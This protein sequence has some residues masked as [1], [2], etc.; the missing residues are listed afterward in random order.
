M[1]LKI[2]FVIFKKN[3]KFMVKMATCVQEQIVKEKLK[4]FLLINLP[5]GILTLAIIYSGGHI[6][7]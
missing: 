3:L 2:F 4:R 1:Y 6:N 5:S 7:E